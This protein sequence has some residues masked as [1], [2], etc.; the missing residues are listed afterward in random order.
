MS[1]Q[2]ASTAHGA[3]IDF[4][5]HGRGWLAIKCQRSL[6]K[7][8]ETD[9]AARNGR[10]RRSDP[11]HPSRV[12]SLPV[13]LLVELLRFLPLFLA[14][15]LL[16]LVL[17]LD[18]DEVGGTRKE[19]LGLRQEL[20]VEPVRHFE[21]TVPLRVVRSHHRRPVPRPP[22]LVVPHEEVG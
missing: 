17:I 3:A 11:V 2:P 4:K 9:G 20:V 19:F 15:P 21:E 22:P 16:P 1:L 18:E 6:T 7:R 5:M 8:R 13:P 12:S 14:D 10:P